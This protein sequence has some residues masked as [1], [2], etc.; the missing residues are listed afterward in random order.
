MS[1]DDSPFARKSGEAR[2]ELLQEIDAGG[3]GKVYLAVRRGVGGF[4]RLVAVKRAHTAVGDADQALLEL[5]EEARLSSRVHHANVASIVDVEEVDGVLML[6]MDYVEGAS[7]SQL[8]RAA[9]L[10]YGVSLRIVLDACAG[11]A[12]VHT[13]RD[14][15][16]TALGLVHRDV[17]PQNLLVG[18]DGHTRLADFGIAKERVSVRTTHASQRKGKPG[19]MAPEYLREGNIDHRADVFSLGAVCWEALT[20]QRLRKVRSAREALDCSDAPIEPP[21]KLNAQL[22]LELDRVVLAALHPVPDER[23]P[24]ADSFA[25]ALRKAAGKQLA[26]HRQVGKMVESVAGRVLAARRELLRARAA[27]GRAPLPAE[28]QHPSRF[29]TR[30]E[31]ERQGR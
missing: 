13:A 12:A 26:S 5:L 29:P 16:G 31:L 6:V 19:Y 1:V 14:E 8:V 15:D 17:S 30:P 21:S 20:G 28:E 18:T 11:L 4:R 22:P 10:P 24:T 27:R 2:F 7:L 3:M 23:Y 9:N 25:D